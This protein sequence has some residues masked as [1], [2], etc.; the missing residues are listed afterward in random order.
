M[1]TT[2]LGIV[3]YLNTIPLIE[4]FAGTA[5]LELTRAVPSRIIDLLLRREVDL[6]LISLIDAARAP[7]PVAI[8]PV[9][10]IGC[11][12]PTLTV[13]L[14]S[15]VPIEQT[16]RVHADTDSH[17]SVTLAKILLKRRH[18][19]TP[20]FVDYDARERMAGRGV[21][22]NITPDESWPQTVL[23]IGDKVVS[24]CP[25]AVRYPH[26]LDLGNAWHDLTGLPFVYAV[27]A[28]PAD[29]ADDPAIHAAAALLDR[30]RRRN[31]ARLDH[32]A[33]RHAHNHGWPQDLASDYIGR[34][35]RYDFDD[36]ATE[37]ART[38]LRMAEEAG[39]APRCNPKIVEIRDF[40][41]TPG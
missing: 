29:R 24:D 39:L 31:H 21:E 15:A 5:G 18:G 30:A 17:T 6:G 19:L 36:R 26:Q 11:D 8:L 2:R 22:P 20:E 28:C 1:Q 12:G 40:V 35:L 23:L 14:F 3:E 16:A 32:I 41:P 13:R 34:L 33:T 10:M 7:D 38:F 9:G 25:P 27:W 37:A 4:G